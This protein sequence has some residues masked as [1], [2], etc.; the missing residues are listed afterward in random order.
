MKKIFT[1]LAAGFLAFG[2]FAQD[3]D[4][5]KFRFGLKMDPSFNWLSVDNKKKFA[6]NG[7]GAGF[8]FGLQTEF[9]LKPKVS[10]VVGA[11][12]SFEG[13]KLNFYPGSS[14]D[15]VHYVLNQDDELQ[16]WGSDTAIMNITGNTTYTLNNRSYRVNYLYV[17]VHLK[18][19]TNEI[20]MLTYF[21]QFGVD[22]KIKTKARA[23]DDI[24]LIGGNSTSVSDIN[25]DSGINPLAIGLNIGG[26]AEFNLSGTTSLFTSL[27]FTYGAI[28][29][30]KKNDDT[31]NEVSES[32]QNSAIEQ[33]AVPH[34]IRLSLGILF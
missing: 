18:M 4:F 26:G 6:N 34:A 15:S 11:G 23:N 28:N 25:I 20:G 29:M 22:L 3:D 13:A 30:L 10:L 12:I 2:T 33:N 24:N 8:G 16:S 9:A 21:G 27:S 14:A 1:L 17:P 7:I 19:K 32:F 31:L 5:K